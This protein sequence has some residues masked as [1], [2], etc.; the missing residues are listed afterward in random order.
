MFGLFPSSWKLPQR[1]PVNDFSDHHFPTKTIKISRPAPDPV[2]EPVNIKIPA[3]EMLRPGE[4]VD[5]AEVDRMLAEMSDHSSD[6][7]TRQMTSMIQMINENLEK[8]INAIKNEPAD[9]NSNV[10]NAAI[11]QLLTLFLNY[12]R[13]LE[14]YIKEIKP[15]LH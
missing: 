12:S 10:S 6:A 2:R 13:N 8:N 3:C 9:E 4:E 7:K 5:M 15:S 14:N 11:L 1:I